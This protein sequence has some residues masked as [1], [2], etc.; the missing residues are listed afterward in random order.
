MLRHGNTQE[1]SIR[2]GHASSHGGVVVV[3]FLV[4][5]I[6]RCKVSEE[7]QFATVFSPEGYSQ[8][9]DTIALKRQEWVEDE[10]V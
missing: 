9:C 6:S 4:N 2:L 3:G 7:T 1:T 10:E 5:Y 8:K